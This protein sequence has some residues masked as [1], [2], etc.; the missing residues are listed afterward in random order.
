MNISYNLEDIAPGGRIGLVALATDYNSETDL[1][2]ML[3]KGVDLFT[4]RVLNANPLTIENLRAMAGDI[5]RAASG[6]LPGLGVDVVIYGCT[7]GTAAIGGEELERLIQ[8]AQPGIPCTNPILAASEALRTFDAKKISILTPYDDAVN[9]AVA[10][11]FKKEDFDIL[12]IDG[13]GLDD[14]IEMTGLPPAAIGEAALQICD[15]DAD[16]LFISCTAIRSSLVI[17]EVEKTLGKPV[18]TSNQALLWHCLQLMK[19]DSRVTG[20]GKLFDQALAS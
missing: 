13:F 6:L 8:I 16:A 7:S 1:R 19:N 4:N 9:A 2:R 10:E 14:D 18:V 11:N 20:F 12:N 5:T 3:P 15:P 17:E